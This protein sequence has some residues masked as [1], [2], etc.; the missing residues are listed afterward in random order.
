VYCFDQGNLERIPNAVLDLSPEI[1]PIRGEWRP[2]SDAIA[3][4]IAYISEA[5]DP[6]SIFRLTRRDLMGPLIFCS[7]SF[8]GQGAPSRMDKKWTS[9]PARRFAVPLTCCQSWW[10]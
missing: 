9:R 6:I 7:K 3:N 10:S 4:A 8:T 1:D 5:I 2:S